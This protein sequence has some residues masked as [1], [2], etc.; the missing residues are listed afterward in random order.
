MRKRYI[1]TL[2]EEERTMLHNLISSG[3]ASAR[4]LTHARILLKADCG[5]GREGWTDPA[6]SEALDVGRSTIER[7]RQLFVEEGLEAAL[8]RKKPRRQYE[9]KLDGEQEAHLIALSCSKP[10]EGRDRW[11]LRLLADKMVVLEYVDSVSHETV[12]QV[13]KKTNSSPG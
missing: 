12:R 1:V 4:K 8:N 10:P 13:L 5:A 7:V 9:R 6:I 3:K 11:S 2:T